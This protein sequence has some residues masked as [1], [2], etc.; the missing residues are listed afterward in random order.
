MCVYVCRGSGKVS[1]EVGGEFGT[2]SEEKTHTASTKL[3]YTTEGGLSAPPP[4][5]I[6]AARG[7]TFHSN[8]ADPDID[9]VPGEDGRLYVPS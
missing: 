3:A 2:G 8:D 4:Q 5:Y 6:R 1:G 7:L 9:E